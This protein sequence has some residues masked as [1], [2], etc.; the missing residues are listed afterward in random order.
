MGNFRP[1]ISHEEFDVVK[2]YRAIKRESNSIDL[3]D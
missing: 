3:D 2:Q 1:R